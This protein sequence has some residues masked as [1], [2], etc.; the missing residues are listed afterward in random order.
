MANG[1]CHFHGGKSTGAKTIRGKLTQKMASWKHGFYSKEAIEE[2]RSV[3][4]M[5]KD[6]KDFLG[7]ILS[8]SSKRLI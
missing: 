4:K 2:R 5:L 6:Q 8:Q 3:K 1:R 7:A